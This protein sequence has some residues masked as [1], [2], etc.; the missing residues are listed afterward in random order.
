MGH[1][2]VGKDAEEKLGTR[3]LAVDQTMAREGLTRYLTKLLSQ[4]VGRLGHSLKAMGP[5]DFKPQDFEEQRA[6]GTLGVGEAV[7]RTA[8]DG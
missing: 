5:K 2:E 1:P 8:V 6:N 4:K 7:M 3:V